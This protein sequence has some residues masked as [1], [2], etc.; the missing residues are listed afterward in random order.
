MSVHHPIPPNP[1]HQGDDL[2]PELAPADFRTTPSQRI[3]GWSAEKQVLFLRALL[4]GHSVGQACRLVGLSKQSA[5]AFRHSPK[6]TGFSLGWDAAVLR[7]RNFLADELMERALHG[8]VETVTRDDGSAVER[9]RYDNRLGMQLLN[10]LDRMADRNARETT[11]AAARLIAQDFDGWLE[12]IAREAGP[13]RAGLYLAQHI[14]P[15]GEADLAPLRA[16]ARADTWLRTHSDLAEPL[17][18]LDPA[19]RADWSGGDWNRA[20][21]AGLVALAPAPPEPPVQASQRNQHFQDPDNPDGDP[22]WWDSAAEDWRT[23]FPPPAGYDGEEDGAYGE[24]DYSRAL[25]LEEAETVEA[26]MRAEIAARRLAEA[27]E[28]DAWFAREAASVP[29]AE[30]ESSHR[31]AELVSASSAPP[32]ISSRGTLDP[33]TSS[34]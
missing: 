22:V 18:E 34:G 29:A 9:H 7:A 20:E 10:R 25:T 4:E 14:E 26:P 16:L 5:Y 8:T 6:G 30:G 13:A 24:P 27:A 28:R 15:A 19:A 1:Y 11:H 21:A 3:T 23:R 17:A 33:E 12:L 2:L 32:V 31:H